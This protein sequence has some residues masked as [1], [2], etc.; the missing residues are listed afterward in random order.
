[1]K[2]LN[3]QKGYPL[4]TLCHM[5]NISRSS[6]YRWIHRKPSLLE[7][8]NEKLIPSILAI[9]HSVDGIYGYRRITMALNRKSAKRY[10][11][12]RIRRLMR[13]FGIKA[14]IRI[15]RKTYAYSAPQ[16]LAENILNRRFK[17]NGSNE[18][19]LCDV[20]ELA[21]GSNKAYLCAILDLGDTSIVSYELRHNNSNEL[22]FSVLNR[23]MEE[24]PYAKPIFHSD[25]GF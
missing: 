21:Y 4:I 19:W 10:N 9:Y 11:S 12:K 25:R 22:V 6:Y 18:K 23:A 1:M 17:A 7:L 2:E 5:L 3:T 8:E 15:K 13:A 14:V 16:V 20:T 24:N